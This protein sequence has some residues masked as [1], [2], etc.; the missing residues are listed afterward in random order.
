[1]VNIKT[2]L[3]ALS[4]Y[5]DP[6]VRYPGAEVEMVLNIKSGVCSEISHRSCARNLFAIAVGIRE[7][8][9]Y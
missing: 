2:T 1:M 7:S 9:I 8:E 4:V 5:M 6:S 3:A